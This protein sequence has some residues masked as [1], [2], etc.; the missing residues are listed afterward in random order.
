AERP[1]EEDPPP[2]LVTVSITSVPSGAEVWVGG[3][4]RGTTPLELD[5]RSGH[6]VS[7]AITKP[8]YLPVKRT[9]TA[10]N[11]ADAIHATLPE[12]TR[13]VGTWR[14]PDGQ[15]REL[16]RAGDRVEVFKRTSAHGGEAT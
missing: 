3:Q 5:A 8:G 9:L 7:V 11:G 2:G 13:F 12:V 6:T 15:L 1:P 4:A 10:G 16:R 14:L